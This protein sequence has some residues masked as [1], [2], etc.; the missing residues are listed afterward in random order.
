MKK[1]LLL[2]I[3]ILLITSTAFPQTKMDIDNLIDIGGLLYAP[4]NNKPY[5]GI[6]FDFYENGTEK[7]NGRYRNGIKNGKWTWWNRDGSI[8]K[9]GTYRD[10]LMNGLWQFYY[11]NDN[12]K[13]KGSYR[14][15]NGAT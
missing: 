3:S 15:G 5:T 2:I 8:V 10:E 7:L 1:I 13:A 6:V 9:R 12:M 4:N 11:W 14:D